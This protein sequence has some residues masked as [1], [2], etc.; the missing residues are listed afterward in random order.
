MS[1]RIVELT[2]NIEDFL[3]YTDNSTNR[4]F[5][6]FITEKELK[7]G[8]LWTLFNKVL[9]EKA[10]NYDDSDNSSIYSQRP[11]TRLHGK[12][13]RETFREKRNFVV[14]YTKNGVEIRHEIDHPSYR[15]SD[16][17]IIEWLTDGTAP[18]YVPSTET[19]VAFWWGSPLRWSSPNPGVY[20]NRVFIDGKVVNAAN[21][22]G[23]STFQRGYWAAPGEDFVKEAE[24][25]TVK[26][27]GKSF[28]NI[29]VDLM[30]S[31]VARGRYTELKKR[32]F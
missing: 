25:T 31:A 2:D 4:S 32:G 20:T 7:S 12:T 26:Q 14:V 23:K 5:Q 15:N 1:F 18:H 30:D 11:S 8:R 3:K 28:R 22:F 9:D 6:K 27:W 19:P 13:L 16:V 21:Y 10:P 17:G 24:I 29:S